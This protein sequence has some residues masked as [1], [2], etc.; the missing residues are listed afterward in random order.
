[1]FQHPLSA[2]TAFEGS[3]DAVEI[4]VLPGVCMVFVQELLFKYMVFVFVMHY[5]FRALKGW[6]AL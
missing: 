3:L 4:K 6:N 2:Q 5:A 1:M